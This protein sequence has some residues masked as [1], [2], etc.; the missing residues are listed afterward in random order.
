MHQDDIRL[1]A[2]SVRASP[3]CVKI[4]FWANQITPKADNPRSFSSSENDAS[5][6][7]INISGSHG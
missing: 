7:E 2:S 6:T 4:T 1:S 5:R 3:S